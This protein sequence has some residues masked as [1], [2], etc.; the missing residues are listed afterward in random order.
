MKVFFKRQ[1]NERQHQGRDSKKRQTAASIAAFAA[2]RLVFALMLIAPVHVYA[3]QISGESQSD[4]EVRIPLGIEAPSEPLKIY[5]YHSTPGVYGSIT[6]IGSDTLATL[7][8][9]WAE[10]FQTLYPHVKFQIQASG[11]ATASQALTQGTASIGPMSRALTPNE[12]QR[13]TRKYGYPPTSLIVAIDAMALYVEKNNPLSRLSLAQIDAIFS[14]TRFCGSPSPLSR[15][16]QLGIGK[17]G[18]TRRIEL[19]GRNSASGTYDL[20]KHL[21]L[22]DGDYDK[23]VNEMPSSSSVVQSVASSIGGMGYAALGH[24]NTDV[25]AVAIGNSEGQYYAPNAE[26]IIAERYPFTRYLYIVVNKPPGEPLPT[27]EKTFLNFILSEQGQKIV[28]QSN[29]YPVTGRL[30]ERQRNLLIKN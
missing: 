15:W 19:F 20:F 16:Q 26:N 27:L 25:K 5:P 17:F 3:G 28:E 13:F 7:I 2:S 18:D 22:C 30:L 1:T 9:L 21:A 10:Q 24:G 14:M 8:S 4:D 29:Y 11:S 23:R 12:I 6:S